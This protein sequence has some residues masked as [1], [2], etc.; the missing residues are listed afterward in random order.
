[1]LY[2]EN[3]QLGF[4]ENKYDPENADIMFAYEDDE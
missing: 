4:T 1:M 2:E 3:C